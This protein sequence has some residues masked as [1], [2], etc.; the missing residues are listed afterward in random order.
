M[1]LVTNVVPSFFQLGVSIK[2]QPERF[3]FLA[4]YWGLMIEICDKSDTTKWV[5]YCLGFRLR[6]IFEQ[7]HFFSV[8]ECY[9]IF[10]TTNVE[11]ARQK[12]TI[13]F[14]SSRKSLEREFKKQQDI[15]HLLSALAIL[16]RA[17]GKIREKGTV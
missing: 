13:P 17:L 14:L 6:N 9:G 2:K 8:K 16:E 12:F 10:E 11:Y 3:R 4:G 5:S 1:L 15:N 7:E